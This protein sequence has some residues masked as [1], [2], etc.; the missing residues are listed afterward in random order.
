MEN[1]SLVG[2]AG[3]GLKDINFNPFYAISTVTRFLKSLS[4]PR[5]NK[6]DRTTKSP[7]KKDDQEEMGIIRIND[8]DSA[9]EGPEFRSGS[10]SS[11]SSTGSVKQI[12]PVQEDEFFGPE[13][14]EVKR[15]LL[16]SGDTS[17]PVIAIWGPWGLGKTSLLK[18][19]YNYDFEI[20]R[21]F[22]CFAWVYMP[23]AGDFETRNI[24]QSIL[25]QLEPSMTKKIMEMSFLELTKQLHS[26]QQEKRCLIVLSGVRKRENWRMLSVALPPADRTKSKILLTTCER[27]FALEIA[28]TAKE[29]SPLNEEQSWQLFNRIVDISSHEDAEKTMKEIVVSRCK[30]SRLAIAILAG[31]RNSTTRTSSGGPTDQMTITSFVDDLKSDLK[32][33]PTSVEDAVGEIV[34]LSYEKLRDKLKQCFLYL[35]HLPLE[36][37]LHVDDLCVRWVYEGLISEAEPNPMKVASH[38]LEELALRNLVQMLE[39]ERGPKIGSFLCCKLHPLV[40]NFCQSEAKKV[41]GSKLTSVTVPRLPSD[42]KG[43]QI[44]L[45]SDVES[46]RLRSLTFAGTFE[47]PPEIMTSKQLLLD[48]RAFVSL[49]VLEFYGVDFRGWNLPGLEIGGLTELWYLS[50][51]RC[52][53]ENLHPSVGELSELKTLD[54]RVEPH[55]RMSVPNILWKLTELERLYFPVRFHCSDDH[56]STTSKLRLTNM[57]K[58]QVLVNFNTRVCDVLDLVAMSKLREVGAVVEESHADLDSVLDTA[59]GRVRRLSLQ[60]RNFNCYSTAKRSALEKLLTC[61]RLRELHLEGYIR[62]LPQQITISKKLTEIV[63][64][65]AELEHDPM[66][67]FGEITNLRSLTLCNDAYVGERMDCVHTGFG[68]LRSLRINNLRK[69]HTWEVEQGAMPKLLSLSI[70]KCEKLVMLPAGLMSVAGLRE[71][72]IVSMPKKFGNRVQVLEGKEGEDVCKVNHVPRI[73]ISSIQGSPEASI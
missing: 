17:G 54:L 32:E 40:G 67:V 7:V 28:D 53:L 27:M 61:G 69:L 64:S 30:G 6:P 24:M 43:Y 42:S 58:L 4:M 62:S 29:I 65:G 52:Y 25:L 5:S 23:G 63:L 41:N 39:E 22:Q 46:S 45:S 33:D 60:V 35:A 59:C 38:Y 36:G 15:L 37:E 72:M 14:E 34:S 13:K 71:L 50:F 56:G 51:Q 1:R 16:E 26:L 57:E 70:E 21:H 73:I 68:E 49:R 12:P 31:Y 66:P 2:R 18:K 20:R 19:L 3:S 11:N 55:C 47:P 44:E 48:F 8:Y 9:E 10:S